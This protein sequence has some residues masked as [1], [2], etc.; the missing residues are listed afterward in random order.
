[1]LETLARQPNVRT[2]KSAWVDVV[3]NL[4]HSSHVTVDF[5][6]PTDSVFARTVTSQVA[7]MARV[8]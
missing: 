1:M 2:E 4:A 6:V 8:V 5:V 7:Q 3:S